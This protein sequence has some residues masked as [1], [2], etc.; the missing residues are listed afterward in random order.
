MPCATLAPKR[1]AADKPAWQWQL[2]AANARRGLDLPVQQEG[3]GEGQVNGAVLARWEAALESE[4]RQREQ[5]E[6]RLHEAEQR[7]EKALAAVGSGGPAD[8]SLLEL[9]SHLAE[10]MESARGRA[11]LEHQLLALEFEVNAREE[12]KAKPRVVY[13]PRTLPL[14]PDFEAP[15][16]KPKAA[17]PAPAAPKDFDEKLASAQLAID[18]A[19]ARA[20]HNAFQVR[21]LTEE[22][23]YARAEQIRLASEMRS[24]R[25]RM[26]G[27]VHSATLEPPQVESLAAPAPLAP[28]P[29]A[30][31]EPQVEVVPQPVEQESADVLLNLEDALEDFGDSGA[32]QEIDSAY[33][34]A[35]TD[36]ATLEDDA[37]DN[38]E[39]ALSAFSD[40]APE[41]HRAA[42]GQSLEEALAAFADDAPAGRPVIDAP[43]LGGSLE[44]AL[45]NFTEDAQDP[46][47]FAA[48]V[49]PEPHAV[50]EEDEIVAALEAWGEA[51][52]CSPEVNLPPE[53][54]AAPAD[55]VTQDWGSLLEV[56]S[57]NRLDTPDAPAEQR[58]AEALRS[59]ALQEAAGG[60]GL[61]ED[62]D[63]AEV[64]DGSTR[65]EPSPVSQ[66][67]EDAPAV[68]GGLDE[69]ERY[70]S[71]QEEPEPKPEPNPDID[72]EPEPV[73][74][75]F[76]SPHETGVEPSGVEVDD[77]VVA[78]KDMGD[79]ARPARPLA[80]D[81]FEER[82]TP[83]AFT[84]DM[85]TPGEF[86]EDPAERDDEIPADE[87]RP[88]ATLHEVA[89]AV[90]EEEAAEEY[91]L[92]EPLAPTISQGAT[93][94]ALEHAQAQRSGN[95]KLGKRHKS[96]RNAKPQAPVARAAAQPEARPTAAPAPARATAPAPVAAPI[97]VTAPVTAAAPAPAPA[98]QPA[99][100]PVEE[101]R[102][103]AAPFIVNV[104]TP[105][106][107]A[108]A[109]VAVEPPAA[110]VVEEDFE[111]DLSAL[112]QR[113]ASARQGASASGPRGGGREAMINALQ[114]FI[115]E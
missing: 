62:I 105:E 21:K 80:E 46:E 108:M 45:A 99:P 13:Q 96:S 110:P 47:A 92:Q 58:I 98:K 104:P 77:L 32:I 8:T 28:P 87:L 61:L 66:E 76:E 60:E 31:V 64:D 112:L 55:P 11:M 82:E 53:D 93:L 20:A 2:G 75:D 18:A 48:G 107:V 4:R 102:E 36:T 73:P 113:G 95:R 5:M 27:G 83:P 24:L 38:I 90:E 16:T 9:K 59:D 84:P 35:L 114:R 57:L 111:P 50:S 33:G 79:P 1:E 30:A 19:E 6:R 34:A 39:D 86:P 109:E 85:D 101:T 89:A 43:E 44:D 91:D 15:R 49:T 70:Y 67:E 63:S 88:A 14:P 3:N 81:D 10:E 51:G 41:A 103:E 26:D 72:P 68:G 78:E 97:Q 100:A 22:L 7:L 23:A 25:D 17:A 74:D 52:G 40:A 29:P 37:A 94:D 56:D 69:T 65:W 106:T 115:G 12:G 71:A 42:A 54:K